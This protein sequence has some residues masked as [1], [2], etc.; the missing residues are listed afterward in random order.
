MDP[1]RIWIREAKSIRIRSTA[2]YVF[3]FLFSPQKSPSLSTPS[4]ANSDGV[5]LNLMTDVFDA[6]GS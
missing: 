1:V 6:D 5:L 2:F 4:L 3:L